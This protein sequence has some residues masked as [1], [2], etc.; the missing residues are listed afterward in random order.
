MNVQRLALMCLLSGLSFFG[1]QASFFPSA[2]EAPRESSLPKEAKKFLDVIIQKV[3]TVYGQEKVYDEKY[4]TQKNKDD[5]EQVF[6]EY[7]AKLP[8]DIRTIRIEVEVNEKDDLYLF[9]TEYRQR[10]AH[11]LWTSGK[12]EAITDFQLLKLKDRFERVEEVFEKAGKSL[13]TY[14][15]IEL[16]K[17]GSKSGNA[18]GQSS[19]FAVIR[20]NYG[21]GIAALVVAAVAWKYHRDTKNKSAKTE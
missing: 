11:S 2:S 5:D 10:K 16:A 18:S 1:M 21:W 4:D 8:T 12:T 17:K 7:L 6:N 3:K 9:R 19:F 20:K 13:T 15:D 14:P